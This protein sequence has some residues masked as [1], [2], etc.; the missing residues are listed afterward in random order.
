ML[1]LPQIQIGMEA[2]KNPFLVE[3][4]ISSDYFCDRKSETQDIISALENGRNVT[5][6]S[7]RRMGKSG[8]I[9]HVFERV[10]TDTPE[11]SCF[12]IDIFHT[13]SLRDFIQ[14]FASNV[15]GVFDSNMTKL[16]SDIIKIFKH[17]RPS[18]S[19]DEI[20]GAPSLSLDIQYGT[21]EHTLKDIFTYLQQSGK[22]CYIAIDEFQ[23]I[24]EYPENG[25]EA[26]LRS[27]IQFLP[28]VNFIFSGSKRHLMSEMFSSPARPFYQSTQTLYLREIAEAEYFSFAQNHFVNSG[29]NLPEECFHTI[30]ATVMSHTWYIQMWLNKLYDMAES[31][32]TLSDVNNALQ[33]ILR[34]EDENFY[35]Y[36][37]VMTPAQR[38]VMSAIAKRRMVDKP[39]AS[40]FLQEYKLPAI[41]TV[42]S[43]IKYL[44]D[45]EFLISDRESLSVYNRFFMLWLAAH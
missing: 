3:G 17:S 2:I 34:E 5:L 16:L 1:L 19:A 23:Q 40:S 27:Y 22:R 21:E 15:I 24:T 37:R 26:L 30:Y 33:K 11:V 38:K 14:L 13:Q 31:D 32:I 28:N 20:T 25:T 9:K 44:T 41:S 42:K 4:Y 39:Y 45:N 35:V 6:I 12:Y 8:L 7:P 43:C 36:S 29:R 18:F 10:K